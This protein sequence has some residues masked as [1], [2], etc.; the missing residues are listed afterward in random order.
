VACA[1][2]AF[3]GLGETVIMVQRPRLNLINSSIA[4]VVAV[5][6]NFWLIP[7][8][9]VTGAA[10]GILIPYLVQGALRYAALRL[11]FRWRNPWSNISPPVVTAI[12]ATIPA[13][14]CRFVWQGIA[15]QVAAALI[16]LAAFGTG[17]I[18][19]FRFRKLEP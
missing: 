5:A 6:A 2:N 17:W 11:V 10:Y 4:C 1:T 16:F 15:G 9:G 8:Y 19:H 12:I 18:Y 13:L 3:V 14:V 7:R